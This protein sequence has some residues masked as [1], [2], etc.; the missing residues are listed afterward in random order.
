MN[1]NLLLAYFD[2]HNYLLITLTITL[3]YLKHTHVIY[4]ENCNYVMRHT[5]LTY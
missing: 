5:N 4:D 3:T 1:E 2:I